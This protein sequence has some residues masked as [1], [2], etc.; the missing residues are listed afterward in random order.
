[1]DADQGQPLPTPPQTPGEIM[2]ARK[3]VRF[4]DAVRLAADSLRPHYLAL[5]LYELAGDFSS[6]FTTDRV[7]DDDPAIRSRRLA[8]CRRT[9][10][11]METGLGLLGL[12][13]LTRM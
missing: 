4:A 10:L 2:L 1:M 12:R 6:F 8:L 11:V 7:L 13:T 3:L 5:Y 9:V